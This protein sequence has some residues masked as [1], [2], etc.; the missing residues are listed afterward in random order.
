MS[1]RPPVPE[2]WRAGALLLVLCLS[3]LPGLLSIPVLDRDEGRFAQASRQM[4]E[5]GDFVDIRFQDEARHKKPVL[6]YWLQSASAAAFGGADAPIGAYR[7]PSLAGAAAGVLLTF[8]AG[9]ALVGRRAAFLGAALVAAT[10]ILQG[11]ARIAKTDAALFAASAAA[12][13]ALAHLRFRAAGTGVALVFWTALA[14]GVLLKGP[15]ILVPVA[16]LALL[17]ALHDRSAGWLGRTRPIAGLVWFLALALPWYV[18]IGLRTG[19]AFFGAALGDDLARKLASGVENHAAPFGS[20]L[21][22]FWVGFWP[23]TALAV[24][25]VPWIWRNRKRA[26]MVFLLAW[27]LPFWLLLEAAP[28]KLPHYPLPLY[29][30]IALLAAWG[31]LDAGRRP[32]WLVGIAAFFWAVGGAALAA[33]PVALP[34]WLDG[35][36]DPLGA[37]VSLLGAGL[38]AAALVPLFRQELVRFQAMAIAAAFVLHAGLFGIALPGLTAP[39]FGERLRAAEAACGIPAAA[40]TGLLGYAEPSAVFALGT[41]TVLA[42][43]DAARALHAAGTPVWIEEKRL[44]EVFDSPAEAQARV[45]GINYNG[46]RPTDLGLYSRD[47]LACPG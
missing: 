25:A 6:I 37:A 8:W 19:G 34:L 18:A 15:L 24:L 29:G 43:P 16:G 26:E 45:A 21:A 28:T 20:Y 13:G 14:A 36:I 22:T 38:A 2:G 46:G 47:R 35:G 11:E 17:V 23:G 4:L 33:L 1:V 40:V 42:T 10:L 44:G 12:M 39:F 7:L 5:T 31:A 9:L 41:E 32:G 30:G 27:I 3:F